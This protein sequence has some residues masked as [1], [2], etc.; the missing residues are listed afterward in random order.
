MRKIGGLQPVGEIERLRRNLE[1]LGRV[2]REQQYVLGVAVRRVGGAEDVA[3]LGARRHA[4]RGPGAL[5]IED[6]RRNFGEI[7]TAR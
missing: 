5:H 3:L 2:L 7:A 1:R 6:H 4:G